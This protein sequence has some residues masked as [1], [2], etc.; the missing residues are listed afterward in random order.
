M[1]NP[2]VLKHT[3]PYAFS[4]VREIIPFPFPGGKTCQ[5][6][7]GVI[8][9]GKKGAWAPVYIHAPVEE[10]IFYNASIKPLLSLSFSSQRAVF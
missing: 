5:I 8:N 6:L 1:E 4:L 10:S 2:V 3:P 7:P 9:M